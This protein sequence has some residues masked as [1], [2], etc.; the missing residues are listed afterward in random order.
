MEHFML[1]KL[2]LEKVAKM[3]VLFTLG[4]LTPMQ[5]YGDTDIALT[6]PYSIPN[7]VN[8]NEQTYDKQTFQALTTYDELKAKLIKIKHS[9]KKN[10]IDVGPLIRNAKNDGLINIDIPLDSDL[11][12]QL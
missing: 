7:G 10:K 11:E 4:I 12:Y 2:I 8:G 3:L 1:N 6:Q 9:A 5:A